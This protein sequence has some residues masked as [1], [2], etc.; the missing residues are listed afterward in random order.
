MIYIFIDI[1]MFSFHSS[2]VVTFPFL[3]F[4]TAVSLFSRCDYATIDTLSAQ[5]SLYV[6]VSSKLDSA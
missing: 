3:S 2:R 5:F 4:N 1:W 6:P